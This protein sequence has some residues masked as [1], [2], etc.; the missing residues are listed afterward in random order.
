MDC[1]MRMVTDHLNIK[2]R[3]GEWADFEDSD[4]DIEENTKAQVELLRKNG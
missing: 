2:I 1:M 4:A 3:S